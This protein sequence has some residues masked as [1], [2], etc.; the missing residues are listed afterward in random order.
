MKTV[1]KN[2]IRILLIIFVFHSCNTNKSKKPTESTTQQTI[3][4]MTVI[5]EEPTPVPQQEPASVPSEQLEKKACNCNAKAYV[6]TLPDGG[7]ELLN[8][9]NEVVHKVSFNTRA[10]EFL[11]L[12]FK[13]AKEN[14]F[15]IKSL[16]IAFNETTQNYEN[17]WIANTHLRVYLPDAD[18]NVP[19]YSAPD[20]T[21]KVL[22]K[23]NAY[24]KHTLTLLGCCKGWMYGL[25]KDKDGKETKAWFDPDSICSNPLSNC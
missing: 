16:E 21:S 9:D 10:E 13:M 22:L 7:V 5:K 3:D 12:T 19:L 20:K 23:V 4:S 14:K 15:Q 18:V 8:D 1:L 2:S 17:L 25:Y 11:K 6:T 24:A